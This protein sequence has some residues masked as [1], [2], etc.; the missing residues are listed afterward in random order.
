MVRAIIVAI[1][2]LALL[3]LPGILYRQGPAPRTWPNIAVDLT[4]DMPPTPGGN[5]YGG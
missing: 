5:R 1:F 4:I 2:L 3:A